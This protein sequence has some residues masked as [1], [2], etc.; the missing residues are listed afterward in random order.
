MD[1]IFMV[2]LAVIA[3]ATPLIS[4]TLAQQVGRGGCINYLG[5]LICAPPGGVILEELGQV[6]CAPG[7][8]FH[9]FGMGRTLCSSQ[10]GGYVV[11]DLGEPKCTGGCQR[12]SASYCQRPQ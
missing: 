1:R 12:P 2:T 8:C 6:L 4:P 9:E 11:K 7:Q 10:P 5:Q 3:I